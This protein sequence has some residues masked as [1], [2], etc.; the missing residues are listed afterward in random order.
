MNAAAPKPIYKSLYF[1]VIT[2][3]VIGV[4]LGHFYAETGT[5]MKPLGDGCIKLI[6][7]IIAPSIFG[8]V[9]VG[10]ALHQG[11]PGLCQART[12]AKH[13]RVPA[14]DH[15]EHLGRR[16]RQGR[17]PP[18]T[19]HRGAVRLPPAPLRRPRPA[20]VRR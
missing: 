6:K 2:A 14:R 18:G 11:Y 5:A 13:H 16:V 7:M 8:T 4:L 19:V 20:G 15:P 12:D 1:Q 3:I 17:A 10:N 9:V